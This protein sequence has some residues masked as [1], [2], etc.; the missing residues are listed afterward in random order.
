[1]KNLLNKG[2]KYAVAILMVFSLMSMKAWANGT[3]SNTSSETGSIAGEKEA[4]EN[5][6]DTADQ[7][8]SNESTK[9]N[10]SQESKNQ[11]TDYVYE[12]KKISVKAVLENANA[13][14]DQAKLEVKEIPE[15]TTEYKK[16]QNALNK[17]STLYSNVLLY[18]I[19]F[20]LDG[21]EVE[22]TDG[23]VK[24]TMSFK[25]QQLSNDLNVKSSNDLKIIHFKD[26]D[27]NK[28]ES[29]K[30]NTN[31][32]SKTTSFE[33][34]SFSTY[35]VTDGPYNLS[36]KG[37]VTSVGI[38]K[39]ENNEWKAVDSSTTFK[40]GDTARI[41]VSYKIPENSIKGNG[42][43]VTY[44][45]PNG[46]TITKEQSGQVLENPDDPSSKSY[47]TYTISTDGLV[48]IK[49]NDQYDPSVLYNGNVTFQGKIDKSKAGES[50]KI[51]FPG[52]S[53]SITIKKDE[54]PEESKTDIKMEKSGTFSS[55]GKSIDYTVTASTT[56]GTASTVDIVDDIQWMTN[57][58]YTKFDPQSLN[59]KKIDKNGNTFPVNLNEYEVKV[60]Q[61]D[62]E[63]AAH[64][65]VKGL[66]KLQAGEKYVLK[67]KMNYTE[68][69]KDGSLTVDNKVTGTSGNDN[70]SAEIRKDQSSL[71]NK[72]GQ[73]SYGDIEWQ[74]AIND[75]QRDI[76]N[77]IFTDT[78][79]D[80]LKIKEFNVYC[81]N[82]GGNQ[83]PVEVTELEN[84]T[85]TGDTR[86]SVDFSKLD[87]SHKDEYKN[88]MFYIRYTTNAPK[89]EG[90]D[91]V[92]YTNKGNLDGND[93]HYES[94]GSVKI[95]PPNASIKKESDGSPTLTDG[96]KLTLKWKASSNFSGDALSEFTYKDEIG[97][98]YNTNDSNEKIDDSHYAI[99][100]ELY[101]SF[102]KNDALKITRKLSD[103]DTQTY[104]V[105]EDF[106]W[107]LKCYD[108]NHNVIK[109]DDTT[110]KVKSFE[111]IVRA[112]TGT[113]FKPTQFVISTYTTHADLNKL[114]EGNKYKFPNTGSMIAFGNTN[115]ITAEQEYKYDR[116]FEKSVSSTGKKA[117][118][119]T[120]EQNITVDE[121]KE[122]DGKKV[123]YYRLLL[124]VDKSQKG[125]ILVEDS[126]PSGMKYLDGSFDASFYKDDYY[127]YKNNWNHEYRNALYGINLDYNLSS[128]DDAPEIEIIA[129]KD[130]SQKLRFKIK[131]GYEKGEEQK[132]QITYKA[133]IS[134]DSYWN[135][136]TKTEKSYTNTATWGDSSSSQTTKV[137]R[138]IKEVSKSVKQLESNG[139]NTNTLE[140]YIDI[141]PAGSDLNPHSDTLLLSDKLTVNDGVQAYLNL[142][143]VH[144]Y[145]YDYLKEKHKG[146]ELDKS[147]YTLTYNAETH[148]MS[149]ELPDNLACVFVYQYTINTGNLAT[150][151]TQIS[152]TANLNG[153]YSSDNKTKFA[154]N[155]SSASL[156]GKKVTLEKVDADNNTVFLKGATFSIEKR[157]NGNWVPQN[158]SDVTAS[159]TLTTG[160]DGK[161]SFTRLA[162]DTLYRIKETKAPEGYRLSEKYYYLMQTNGTITDSVKEDLYNKVDEGAKKDIGDI[163]NVL[164]FG[165]GTGKFYVPNTAKRL[166]VNKSWV[167]K[168]NTSSD[169]GESQVKM[170]LTR[171]IKS[172]N[173][174]A[175]T[176]WN[177]TFILSNDNNW[178]KYWDDLAADDGNGHEY[179]YKVEE[180]AIDGY[181]AI[182][183]G[184]DVNHGTIKVINKGEKK[185]ILPSTGGNGTNIYYQIGMLLSMLGFIY[186]V[187]KKIKGGTFKKEEHS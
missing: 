69:S 46:I 26:N 154:I 132:F 25:D 186:V 131:K 35:A 3:D 123:L 2:F 139:V 98:A 114:T 23:K 12:D 182:Y 63:S 173:N 158:A 119:K 137:N 79:P 100:K 36:D 77:Y 153:E 96:D 164:F 87:S 58:S 59:L 28:Q 70:N 117:T 144:L 73:L 170:T 5:Q 101:D 68:A 129:N 126:L 184:N 76:S 128:K 97:D 171:Y 57:V 151:A 82:Q 177:R 18:N 112:K 155:S 165:K 157:E 44:Q 43:V 103:Y 41:S 116:K 47:G 138:T 115:S 124:K 146:S 162:D 130:G 89:V 38:E 180:E 133:E 147:L 13:I 127:F 134:S 168:D 27:V 15:T 33:T 42:S 16:Y 178:T 80:G 4:D 99:A 167:H 45:I 141:N 83:S 53:T 72:S 183:R 150:D 51:N 34:N 145:Q 74:V 185:T 8:V 9:S 50:G 30:T 49:F 152:N 187:I 75:A 108:K 48:T 32:K 121:M 21:K 175:K 161:I 110:S 94:S 92:T 181:E 66:P 159:D 104:K 102:N 62:W 105:G 90:N 31:V 88:K 169:P 6:S 7:L 10:S 107:E 156:S 1:M 19:S 176:D 20:I 22:P 93:H 142:E 81:Y 29:L 160:E 179:V 166:T 135:D 140:Y 143:N 163:K 56:K 61:R 85:K 65:E 78:L 37:W 91:L 125:D 149:V 111:I 109:N 106:T 120:G 17:K 118:Y 14:S 11:K 54:I 95:S 55:D 67:Y 40:D 39:K 113:E 172:G 86:I 60:G 84:A 64:L 71:I 136:M 148:D 52:S 122:E 174:L 24:V